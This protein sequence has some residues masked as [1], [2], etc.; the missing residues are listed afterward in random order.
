[1]GHYK[2]NLRDIEFNMFEVS[3]LGTHLAARR[4]GDFDEESVRHILREVERLA[5]GTW[6]DSF[7]DGDRNPPELID[8]EAKLPQSLKTSLDA[9]FDA[10][11]DRVAMLPE[12]GGYG[13]PSQLRWAMSEMFYGGNAVASFYLTGLLIA[14]IIHY[15][16][17]DEQSDTFARPIIKR[18]WGGT[19]VLTEPDAGSDVG[20]GITKAIAVDEE[21]GLY[22]I[23]GVK[24]FITSGEYDYPENIIHLVLARRERGEPGTKGLSMFIVPKYLLNDDGSIGDRNGVLA[25]K[26]ENKMGMRASTTCELTFGMDRPCVGYL[27]GGVHQGIR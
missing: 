22:H 2:A 15:E 23:E 5:T 12:L 11:W 25:T 18:R 17:T 13:A 21:S 1:M 27:V 24:R 6:A 3:D 16:G 19:M 14:A 7:A 4:F 26:L 9:Y 10:G 20:A 8:G